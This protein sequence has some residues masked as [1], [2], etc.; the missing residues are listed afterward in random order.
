MKIALLGGTGNLGKG[1]ALRLA[2]LGYEVIIGSRKP[3]KAEKKAREY[4]GIVGGDIVGTDNYSAAKACDIAVFTIPWEHAFSTAETLK[5][6][7]KD[8]VVVSPLVPMKNDGGV[9]VY[10]RPAEGSAAEKLA[11]VLDGSYIIAAFHTLPAGRFAR[12]EEKLEWDVP[13]CGDDAGAKEKIKGIARKM[14]LRPLD[15]GPLSNAYLLESLTPLIL[16]IMARNEVGELG[17][18]FL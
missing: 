18:K 13:V 12:I 4:L 6:P 1:L 11:K 8:K 5:V 2:S 7:L 15:A 17:V 14:G 16:N 3:E 9:F 10:I